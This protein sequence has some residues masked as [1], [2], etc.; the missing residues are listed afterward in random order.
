MALSSTQVLKSISSMLLLALSSSSFPSFHP[1]LRPATP[2]QFHLLSFI[3][4]TS[5]DS[6]T[7]LS[8]L[9]FSHSLPTGVPMPVLAPSS[10]FFAQLQREILKPQSHPALALLKSSRGFQ[11]FIVKVQ[12]PTNLVSLGP[13]P[14]FTGSFQPLAPPATWNPPGSPNRTNCFLRNSE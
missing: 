5:P 3:T 9:D 2:S 8:L 13:Q 1:S 11:L 7:I 4:V 10:P 6:V 14:T 12:R